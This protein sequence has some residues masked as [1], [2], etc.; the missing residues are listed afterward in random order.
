M[1]ED[2]KITFDHLDLNVLI[3]N[4][5]KERFKDWMF[6][7]VLE[8]EVNV[9]LINDFS[10]RDEYFRLFCLVENRRNEMHEN[11]EGFDFAFWIEEYERNR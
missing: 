8:F 7:K 11:I 4:E 9:S 10:D 2:I 5:R 6:E 1:I 3:G